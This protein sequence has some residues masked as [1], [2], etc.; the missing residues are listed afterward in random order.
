MKWL[1]SLLGLDPLGKVLDALNTAY[2]NKLNATT[3][4]QRI[5]AQEH[6]DFLKATL[7][8]VQNARNAAA[9]YP[10]W[11]AA[12]MAFIAI[13]MASHVGLI[14]LGTTLQ[15]LIFGSWLGAWLLHIPGLPSPYDVS[16]SGV[17]Q[18]FFGAGA[19]MG[20]TSIVAKTFKKV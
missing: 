17:L 3:E 1:L 8:D 13:C 16:E 10:W 15:P 11:L 5:A 12:P 19:A 18:F 7:A 2:Q 20:I 9:S 6:I 14:A 4:Q